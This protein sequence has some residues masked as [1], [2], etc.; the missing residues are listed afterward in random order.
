LILLLIF[1]YK[2]QKHLENDM[3]I[4]SVKTLLITATASLALSVQAATIQINGTIATCVGLCAALSGTG[5]FVNA[6]Y[7]DTF[8]VAPNIEIEGNAGGVLTFVAQS[9]MQNVTSMNIGITI[10]TPVTLGADLSTDGVNR[11]SV[12]G[13]GST[14]SAPVWASFDLN[15]NTFES[16]LF[17][18]DTDGQGTPGIL[19]LADGTFTTT[20]VPVPAAA[21]LMISGLVGLAGAKRAK[22][23]K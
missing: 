1:K 11:V 3:F 4:K 22:A 9:Y 21:W 17:T 6:T 23:N 19:A 10:P 7:D 8:A 14:T 16:W 18:T 12:F 5:N 20:V 15:N 2:N 13:V